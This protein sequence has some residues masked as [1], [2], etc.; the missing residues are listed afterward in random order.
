MF[1]NSTQVRRHCGA[2]V[3]SLALIAANVPFAQAT[4]D[5]V[6]RFE[7]RPASEAIIPCVAAPGKTPKVKVTIKRGDRNDQMSVKLEG[8]KPGIKFDLFTVQNSLFQADGGRDANFK[9]FGLSWYQTDLEPGVTSVRT[10]LL[11]QIFGFVQTVPQ[12]AS[13][14]QPTRT[15]HVGFWFNNPDDAI[16]CNPNNQRIVTPFNGE[17]QAGPLAF[18]S[19]P[20]P[21]TNLGPLCTKPNTSTSPATCDP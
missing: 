10:I 5:D 13:P 11:D 17:L 18:I 1:T 7:L 21:Y 8:F 15:F 6:V 2:I 19:V 14:L 9:G 16:A 12:S 4:P 3:G 20:D